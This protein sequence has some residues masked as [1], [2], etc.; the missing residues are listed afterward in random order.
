MAN[1]VQHL[2]SQNLSLLE[3]NKQIKVELSQH[4]EMVDLLKK[5]LDRTQQALEVSTNQQPEQMDAYRQRIDQYIQE[6]DKCIEWLQN[7]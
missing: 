5:K 4:R 7:A 2:E 3:E 6:I 1:R